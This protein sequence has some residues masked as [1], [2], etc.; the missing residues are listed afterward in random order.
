MD[1][2][3]YYDIKRPTVV[4]FKPEQKSLKVMRYD[5]MSETFSETQVRLNRVLPELFNISEC[6]ALQHPSNNSVFLITGP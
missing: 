5:I 1:L 6:K 2:G 4:F 3:D